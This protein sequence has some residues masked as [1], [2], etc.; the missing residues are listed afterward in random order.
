MDEQGCQWIHDAALRLLDGVGCAVLEPEALALL[1]KHGA[2]ADGQRVRFGQTLVDEAL[3]TVPSGYT[4]AG[5]R[6]E[7]DLRVALDALVTIHKHKIGNSNPGQMTTT[8][9][10]GSPFG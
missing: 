5:R 8:F 9:P 10:T 3:A 6:P 4:V 2:R 7:L 1:K